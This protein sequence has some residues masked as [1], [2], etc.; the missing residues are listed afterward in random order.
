MKT[1][2]M[3]SLYAGPL[4]CFQPGD[5]T[6]LE[7]N[8]ADALIDGKYAVEVTAKENSRENAMRLSS[9]RAAHVPNAEATARTARRKIAQAEAAAKKD[10]EP[11]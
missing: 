10:G 2:R 6:R 3:K 1:V 9:E 4:G 11:K 5:T 7:D 8:E